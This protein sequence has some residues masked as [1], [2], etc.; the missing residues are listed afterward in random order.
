V[1]GIP[2][3]AFDTTGDGPLKGV[4]VIDISRLV[5]GN[6]ASLQLGDFGAEV[7]K[8]EDPA[9]G[10]P[11]RDWR[12]VGVS[13]YW[14]VYGRN[15]KSLALNIR[16]K[17]GMALLQKL[18]DTADVVI[19]NFR[20]GTME[21][22]G[23]APA[24]LL[25]RNPRLVIAR[26]S[27]FGQDGPYRDRPGF[28][29]SVEG[30][31]GFAA[32]NGFRDRQPVLPPMPLADMIAGLYGAFSIMVALRQRDSAGGR[33]QV[34]DVP[35][36]DSVLSVLGPDAAFY[37]L[38]GT[39]PQ[40][41][42]GRSLIAGPRNVFATK[43]GQWISVAAPMQPMA[44]RLFIAIGRPDMNEDPRFATNDARIKHPDE[45][46]APIA[47]FVAERTLAE[48]LAHFEAADVTVAPIYGPD[49]L[50]ADPHVQDRGIVVDVPDDQLG[51]LPMHNVVPRLAETPGRLQ[52]PAPI[53]GEH[54]RE[55]LAALG[56]SDDE[57]AALAEAGVARVA[58]RPPEQQIRSKAKTSGRR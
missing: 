34:I 8:L 28:G 26:V 25:K 11:L 52:R 47:A 37:R 15:K 13:L 38:T 22:V 4:R 49:L 46:D 39:L 6:M 19:E 12:E 57:I 58:E 55:V 20:P 5:A 10:D 17:R 33:G 40:R 42:G 51:W 9:R 1:T 24:E 3:V 16:D 30:M 43:D 29:T 48:A 2:K 56:C 32:K 27:G 45:C 44:E 31:A 41:T 54:T 18:I 35:L 7:I 23:L 21:K 50:M 36:I 14:K 53:I